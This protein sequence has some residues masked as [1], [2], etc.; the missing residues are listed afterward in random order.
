MNKQRI[1]EDVQQKKNFFRRLNLIYKKPDLE[2]RRNKNNLI[3]N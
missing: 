1:K 3:I 2:I